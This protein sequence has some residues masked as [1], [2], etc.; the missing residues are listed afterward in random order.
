MNKIM[1]LMKKMKKE[2]MGKKGMTTEGVL[3]SLGIIIVLTIV[4]IVMLSDS[5]S[6]IKVLIKSIF[7]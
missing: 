4:I 7:G 6:S 1:M 5:S 3:I 2:L